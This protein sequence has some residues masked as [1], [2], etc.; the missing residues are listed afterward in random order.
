[1]SEA[2]VPAVFLQELD[3]KN[4]ANAARNAY[5]T[6]ELENIMSILSASGIQA[7]PVKGPALAKES[8]GD[9]SMRQFDDLDVLIKKDEIIS[10]AKVMQSHGFSPFIS[11]SDKTRGRHIDAGWGF[12]LTSPGADYH[13]ELLSN[14]VPD[15]Y[16]FHFPHDILSCDLHNIEMDGNSVKTLSPENSLILL[17]VH[18]AKHAWER[19][20]WIADIIQTI[21]RTVTIDL[22]GAVETAKMSGGLRM[23]LLGLNLSKTVSS[24]RLPTCITDE[25]DKD[26]CVMKLTQQ[27][28]SRLDANVDFH[29]NSRSDISFQLAVRERRRDK[30]KYL[31]SLVFTPSYGDWQAIDL[32]AGLCPVYFIIRPI[33]L[34]WSRMSPANRE[35]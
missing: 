3:R 26:N 31:S 5:L 23:L 15:V 28:L 22:P 19:L 32:P 35:R 8:Y 14:I 18:G 27:I 17:C 6:S 25:I 33:R 9:I 12:S 2:D 1:M 21:E 13:L 11:M 16:A 24:V 4:I 34:L 7:I 29:E 10:A 20:G 30:L